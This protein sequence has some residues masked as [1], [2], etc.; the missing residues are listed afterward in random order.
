[1]AALSTTTTPTGAQTSTQS[2]QAAGGTSTGT[3]SSSVQPGTAPNLLNAQAAGGVPLTNTAI[4]TVNLG[5]TSAS[6]TTSAKV[7]TPVST[8]QASP[9]VLGISALFFVAAIVIFALMNRSAKN[10]TV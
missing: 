4:T 6:A 7:N 9:A 2:P 3:R 10:T 8:S 5:K 1:M